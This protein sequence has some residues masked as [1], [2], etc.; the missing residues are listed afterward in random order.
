MVEEL[1][2]VLDSEAE[3]FVIK[4]WR[5]LIYEVLKAKEAAA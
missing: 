4:L 3:S 5:M 2:P 1:A